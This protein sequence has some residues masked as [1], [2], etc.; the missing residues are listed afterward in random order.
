LDGRIEE[1]FLPVDGA[2]KSYRR[3]V[4]GALLIAY[5]LNYLDR[6]L[7]SVLNEPIRKA[8]H[9]GDFEMGLL[10]GPSFAVLFAFLG[11][12]LARLADRFDRRMIIALSV[13]IWSVMTSLCGLVGWLPPAMHVVV[14][15]AV[16]VPLVALFVAKKM[17][18]SAALTL[19]AAAIS[20]ALLPVFNSYGLLTFGLLL[21]T[22][23]GVGI[24]E[25]GGAPPA[26]SLLSDYYPPASR[27][28]AM[29][30]FS[31]GIPLGGLL[32]AVGG[33]FLAQWLGWRAAFLALGVP[34]I[35]IGLAVFYT[36]REPQ[37]GGVATSP[38]VLEVLGELASRPT[39]W[40][41]VAAASI[42]AFIAYGT[43][44]FAFAY[45]SRA[46]GLTVLQAAALTAVT[47]A[48][49]SAFGIV[50][51]GVAS[52]RLAKRLPSAPVVLP[53]LAMIAATP[54]L[55]LAFTA[56]TPMTFI[57][58]IAPASML[59]YMYIGPI[60]ATIQTL[61]PTR[62]R[63]T[64]IAIFT[65]T[66][67]LVGFGLGPPLVGLLSDL[68]T[69]HAFL[70][71]TGLNFIDICAH[72]IDPEAACRIAETTGLRNSML[73]CVCGYPPAGLLLLFS[74]RTFRRDTTRPV[75]TPSLSQSI[76]AP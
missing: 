54:L 33:G 22:R 36:V 38:R 64:A 61:A 43:G 45:L 68:Q 28:T 6:N 21:M 42:S 62:M 31:L 50:I 51:G 76:A 48:F 32:A 55:L 20:I 44:Q 40:K 46:Y 71:T 73:I 67:T 66:T 1:E 18:L 30:I 26:I 7:L 63:A 35:A 25:A 5:C 10:G 65:F 57:A 12:P 16:L 15:S 29:S 59:Q 9:L 53:G 72:A 37:R 24:G 23:L 58:F 52:D 70:Q 60:T 41:T 56:P 14:F 49:A 47:A 27:A 17:L 74:A 69:S 75:G 2:S 4:L 11:L 34:G 3:Y 39:F 19:G 8:L 13:V